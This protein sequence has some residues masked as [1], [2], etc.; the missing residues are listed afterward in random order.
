MGDPLE[1]AIIRSHSWGPAEAVLAETLTG[2][3]ND[4]VVLAADVR[5]APDLSQVPIPIVR[6]DEAVLE[7]LGLPADIPDWG[8]RC[9][10]Y[11][12]IATSAAY[13]GAERLW[14]LEPDVVFNFDDPAQFFRSCAEQTADLLAGRFAPRGPSW[15]HHAA[16]APYFDRVMGCFYPVTRLTRRAVEAVRA[17]RCRIAAVQ[18]ALPEAK[19][20]KVAN[21]ESMVACTIANRPGLRGQTLETVVPD[22]I[23]QS[24]SLFGSAQM[25]LRDRLERLPAKLLHPV[26][27][28]DSFSRKLASKM[29]YQTM[30]Y[31]SE[32]V[33]REFGPEE[34]AA[35][36]QRVSQIVLQRHLPGTVPPARSL[37]RAMIRQRVR[38]AN[39]MQSRAEDFVCD[40]P[41]HASRIDV[42]RELPYA[43]D[44]KN[45][46]LTFVDT[47][48]DQVIEDPFLFLSQYRNATYVLQT[49]PKDL[50]AELLEDRSERVTFVFSIGRCGS[51]LVSNLAKA[52]GLSAYSECD[53]LVGMPHYNGPGAMPA[54][55]TMVRA[56]VGALVSFAGDAPIVIK[57]KAQSNIDVRWFTAL[58]PHARIVFLSRRADAWARSCI[59]VFDWRT[60]QLANTIRIGTLAYDHLTAAGRL[61][62]FLRY[63]DLV[64]DASRAVERLFG[65]EA[66]ARAGERLSQTM[67]R[68]S[69]S[70]LMTRRV[71]AQEV[72]DRRIAEFQ[73]ELSA[74][75]RADAI[76]ASPVYYKA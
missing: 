11:F 39:W 26:V 66:A 44:F 72:I 68:E 1:I 5:K 35:F 49:R 63:E 53:A 40:L 65:H 47:H 61:N 38:R 37:N 27:D 76:V 19:R 24:S 58:F 3:F 50:P 10:D 57:M 54:V 23:P 64:T 31:Y 42:R 75:P 62:A 46:V 21:D 74:D 16:V 17:E 29:N 25:L 14:M 45:K 28:R 13:P 48:P 70:G 30:P 59:E 34:N 43:A 67:A 32:L 22:L 4:R 55:E 18:A 7:N 69:Q 71:P 41:V 36:A 73:A 60:P 8:W 33:A 20:P 9:G 15:A 2:W 51:T 52:C 6:V 56:T 12:Q